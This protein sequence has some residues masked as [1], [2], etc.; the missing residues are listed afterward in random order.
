VRATHLPDTSHDS[1]FVHKSIRP[2]N[3][4]LFPSSTSPMGSAY[5]LGFTN[6]RSLARQ[7]NLRGDTAWHRNLCMSN[8]RLFLLLHGCHMLPGLPMVPISKKV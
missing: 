5:L 1:S 8:S 3:I 7:T 2:E 4:I 6:F